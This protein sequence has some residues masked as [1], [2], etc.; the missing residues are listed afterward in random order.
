MLD[1][2]GGILIALLVLGLLLFGIGYIADGKERG[3]TGCGLS[4]L[5][6]AGLILFAIFA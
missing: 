3:D 1:A 5:V 6:I 2:A 4:L